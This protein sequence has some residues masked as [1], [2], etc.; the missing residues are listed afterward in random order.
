MRP[1]PDAIPR[2]D[3]IPD[4]P[5][6]SLHRAV[7]VWYE[8]PDAVVEVWFVHGLTGS[9]REAWAAS[10]YSIPWPTSILG[11][12]LKAR[13]LAFGYPVSRSASWLGAA[14]IFLLAVRQVSRLPI[15]F[16]A[17]GS[18]GLLCK[19]SYWLSAKLCPGILDRI[20]G[21]I[22]I[23]TPHTD[24][25]MSDWARIPLRAL[26]IDSDKFLF[27]LSEAKVV[28]N[29]QTGF[30][31][32]IKTLRK[33]A[34]FKITCFFEQL[35]L[36]RL[37][38]LVPEATA[39]LNGYKSIGLFADHLTMAKFISR[40]DDG[41]K[42]IVGELQEWQSE[43]VAG[44]FH[45]LELPY[46]ILSL[47]VP[48]EIPPSD[49]SETPVA[50]PPNAVDCTPI[51]MR[52]CLGELSTTHP[53]AALVD[54]ELGRGIGCRKSCMWVLDKP[55][56]KQWLAVEPERR[57]GS[58]INVLFVHGFYQAYDPAMPMVILE[59]LNS[60]TPGYN[61]DLVAIYFFN[62]DSERRTAAHALHSLLAQSIQ[63]RPRLSSYLTSQYYSAE[64]KPFEDISLLWKLFTDMAADPEVGTIFWVIDALQ[65]CD[66]DSQKLLL[67]LLHQ[68]FTS[69]NPP[70]NI[71]IFI[72]CYSD[73]YFRCHI[74]AAWILEKPKTTMQVL[75]EEQPKV[76]MQVEFEGPKITMQVRP[77]KS[78]EFRFGTVNKSPIFTGCE[79]E[80]AI[81]IDGGRLDIN[82]LDD[83]G[84]SHLCLAAVAG[85]E[86]IVKVLLQAEGIDV[87]L[88]D[89]LG[90]TALSY[91]FESQHAGI[92]RLLLAVPGIE[93]AQ[94]AQPAQPA[95]LA[96]PVQP[97]RPLG[98][99]ASLQS[100]PQTPAQ[101]LAQAQ[102]LQRLPFQP[103][104]RQSNHLKFLPKRPGPPS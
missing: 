38:K 90:K 50:I 27:D 12:L 80:V 81:L 14:A 41:F 32:T 85:Y 97:M 48:L 6:D 42:A 92:V 103:G 102:K 33:D 73:K 49:P 2:P 95:Q 17:Y 69:T 74:P 77:Y 82:E 26:G 29:I 78:P 15:I 7:S 52:K 89:Y 104:R 65:E 100:L 94:S 62:K 36:P 47:E 11:P 21:I 25:W 76:K 35:P 87:N 55:V 19:T 10:Q 45:A 46:E 60:E 70:S 22:F 4:P 16:V 40:D 37:G 51:D 20:K 71:R 54:T 68:T 9:P 66:E 86:E 98:L 79:E 31:N 96:Q 23:G 5:S 13:I 75:F 24:T 91:A 30:E 3:P 88:K 39:T 18:G 83:N 93:T 99:A 58:T 101:T 64:S 28:N 8:C 53:L 34:G 61:S 44:D 43:V 72:S 84:R 59:R 1:I 56:V 57:N 63:Q 67:S